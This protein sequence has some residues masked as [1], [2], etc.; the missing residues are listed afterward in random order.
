MIFMKYKLQDIIEEL[1]KNTKKY[2]YGEL[3]DQK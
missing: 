3:I 1:E 2:V